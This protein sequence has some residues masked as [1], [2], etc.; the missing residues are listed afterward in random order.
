MSQ[1]A[2]ARLVNH[3]PIGKRKLLFATSIVGVGGEVIKYKAI[4]IKTKIVF[5]N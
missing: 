3:K 2:G 1:P 5:E 4:L